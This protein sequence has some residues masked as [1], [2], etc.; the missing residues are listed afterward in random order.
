MKKEALRES[1]T[2]TF[3]RYG[4][5]NGFRGRSAETILLKEIRDRDGKMVSDHLWFNMTKGFEGLGTLLAGEKLLFQARVTRYSKGYVNKKA[6]I[7][8]R[9]TDFKLSHPTRIVKLS[10]HSRPENG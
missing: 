8:H 2:G 6:G 5:K 9:S 3:N 10:G 7:S 1:F 4:S